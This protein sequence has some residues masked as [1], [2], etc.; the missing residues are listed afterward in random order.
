MITHHNGTFLFL[1]HSAPIAI[2]ITKQGTRSKANKTFPVILL[3]LLS[4]SMKLHINTI[5][6]TINVTHS[7]LN[8]ESNNLNKNGENKY[9]TIISDTNHAPR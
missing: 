5:I 6:V 4:T 3:L 9:K 7:H 2:P 8:F 1:L